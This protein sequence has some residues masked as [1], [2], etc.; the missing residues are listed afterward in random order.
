LEAKPLDRLTV[1]FS[2]GYLNTKYNS[3]DNPLLGNLAGNRFAQATSARRRSATRT[4]A[5]VSYQYG[6]PR[7]YGVGLRYHF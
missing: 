1:D 7:S 3:C 2:Y 5:S 4:S 6:D